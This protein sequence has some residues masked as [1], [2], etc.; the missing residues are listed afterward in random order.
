MHY[1]NYK[2]EIGITKVEEELN[3][4]NSK[5]CRIEIQEYIDAK[6]KANEVLVPLYK[7]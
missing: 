5:S 6:L 2:D 7:M 4:H 3:K 1:Q